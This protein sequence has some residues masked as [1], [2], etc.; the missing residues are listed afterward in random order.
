VTQAAWSENRVDNVFDFA[1]LTPHQSLQQFVPRHR[2]TISPGHPQAPSNHGLVPLG[3]GARGVLCKHPHF[4][5]VHT[6]KKGALSAL[7]K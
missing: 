4:T 1:I 5:R 2:L 7:W 6:T 3:G